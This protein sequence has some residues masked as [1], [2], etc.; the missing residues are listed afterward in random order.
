[1]DY[2][3]TPPGLADS[4]SG[5]A[6]SRVSLQAARASLCVLQRIACHALELWFAVASCAT[7]DPE[8]DSL[9]STGMPARSVAIHDSRPLPSVHNPGQTILGEPGWPASSIQ[10]NPWQS[11]SVRQCRGC[12]QR[13]VLSGPLGTHS[14]HSCDASC[15]LAS[16][17]GAGGSRTADC[18]RC[19]RAEGAGALRA[20]AVPPHT[21]LAHP[22]PPS[23]GHSVHVYTSHFTPHHAFRETTDGTLSVSAHGDFLPV[24]LWQRMHIV[25]AILRSLYLAAWVALL[26][27]SYDLFVCDQVNWSRRMPL[28][29]SL[30]A[31]SGAE[32]LHVHSPAAHASPAHSCGILLPLSRSVAGIS[33]QLVEASVP[34]AV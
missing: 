19:S 28:R 3:S 34:R 7:C 29:S 32:G 17:L 18:G 22:P 2:V 20:A 25:C 8:L 10:N 11:A 12:A 33:S 31:A 6:Q 9:L 5:E 24:H 23:Q 27:P 30:P 21:Q 15:D 26:G 13:A 1:M 14:G 16:R 4:L